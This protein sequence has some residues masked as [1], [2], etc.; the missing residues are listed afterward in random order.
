MTKKIIDID[1]EFDNVQFDE[2]DIQRQTHNT[3]LSLAKLGKVGNKCTEERKIKIGKKNKVSRMSD[4]QRE[5]LIKSNK[6][7]PRHTTPHTDETKQKIK[8]TLANKPLIICP[9]CN[10]TG[11][12]GVMYRWHFDNCKHKK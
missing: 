5:Q 7:N 12:S 6:E 4:Y 1:L 11:K 8:N 10:T 3:K 2:E 9:Y